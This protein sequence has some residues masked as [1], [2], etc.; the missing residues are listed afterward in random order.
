MTDT[1]ISAIHI[2]AMSKQLGIFG[3]KQ[4]YPLYPNH[5]IEMAGATGVF[6]NV[7]KQVKSMD[8]NL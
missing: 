2:A 4:E 3:Q 7:L 8:D 5:L 1:R 6:T